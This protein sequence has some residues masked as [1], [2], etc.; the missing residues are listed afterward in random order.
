MKSKK[1]I[2]FLLILS[3]VSFFIGCKQKVVSNLKIVKMGPTVIKVGKDF[4]IQPD[5]ANA[6]WIQT[7]NAT[8]TTVVCWEETKLKT[9]VANPQAVSANVPKELYSKPGQY[10]VYLLDTQT[11]AKSNVM[12]ITVE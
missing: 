12:V 7:E 5:G 9:A 11:G 1:L 2:I 6:I 4:N 8:K 3:F 10:Q